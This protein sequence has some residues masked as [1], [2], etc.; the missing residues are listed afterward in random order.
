MANNKTLG[1]LKIK[2]VNV[3]LQILFLVLIL[4]T[5]PSLLK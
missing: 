3:E 5:A 1:C 2:L 4:K